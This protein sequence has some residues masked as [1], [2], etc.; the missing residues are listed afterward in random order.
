[1]SSEEQYASF[2]QL[3]IDSQGALHGLLFAILA[4]NQEA[5][6]VLQETNTVILKKRT[7]FTEGTNFR[8]WVFQI[9]RLQAKAHCKR[10]L[11]NR[12]QF[13][14][15]L[16]NLLVDE[17]AQ[18]NPDPSDHLQALRQ[19]VS[20]LSPSQRDLI[21]SRYSGQSVK[22]LADLTQSTPARVSRVLFKIRVLAC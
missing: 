6:E 10:N 11:R 19:C 3:L 9:A 17:A 4:D 2:V 13:D 12:L 16:I 21:D 1:M 5:D 20:L 15:D 7:D 18:R 22:S 8:A 14:D